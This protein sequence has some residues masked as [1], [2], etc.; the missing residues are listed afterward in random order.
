MSGKKW[1]ERLKNNR[2]LRCGGFSVLLTAAAVILVLLIAALA[3]VLEKRYALQADLSF[4]AAT[5]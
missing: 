4:N 5:T 2:K 3:D 1:A